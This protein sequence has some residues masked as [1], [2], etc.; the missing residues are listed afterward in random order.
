[1]GFNTLINMVLGHGKGGGGKRGEEEEEEERGPNN[2]AIYH[3]AR[4]EREGSIGAYSHATSAEGDD[5]AD[6]FSAFEGEEE[7][8]VVQQFCR[9]HMCVDPGGV[10]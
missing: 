8:E 1:M 5:G 9:C 7:N 3:V 4:E 10:L 2:K 6:K